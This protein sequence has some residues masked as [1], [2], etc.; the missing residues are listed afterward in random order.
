VSNT[1]N[2]E[3]T[4]AGRTTEMAGEAHSSQIL[5]LLGGVISICFRTLSVHQD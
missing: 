4:G 5:G 3:Q 1:K 2:N